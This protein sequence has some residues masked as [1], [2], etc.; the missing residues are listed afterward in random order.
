MMW[1]A[2][3]GGRAATGFSGKT[4]DCVVRAIA[5]ACELPYAEVY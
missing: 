5:I 4:G 1:V 2:D 3:D